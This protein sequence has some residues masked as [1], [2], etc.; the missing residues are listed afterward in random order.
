M[1]K[2]LIIVSSI[3]VHR[4]KF[5]MLSKTRRL[6]QMNHLTWMMLN[7]GQ[8]SNVQQSFELLP[9]R[10]KYS[11][12]IDTSLNYIQLYTPPYLQLT[13]LFSFDPGNQRPR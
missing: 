8:D 3:E 5:Q 10:C 13:G 9:K 11:T 6:F 2:Q 1:L 4:L 12:R 7:G